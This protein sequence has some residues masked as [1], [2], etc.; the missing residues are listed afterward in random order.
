MSIS[1]CELRNRKSTS[2]IRQARLA[3]LRN[4]AIR[5]R[6]FLPRGLSMK[7]QISLAALALAFGLSAANAQNTGY[8]ALIEQHIAA[9]TKAAK[10]DMPGP[11]GLC[12]TATPQ[13]AG[14]FMDYYRKMVK[15][16]PLQPMQ[17]MDELYFLGN[18]WTSSWA[19]KTS[20]GLVIIDSLDNADEAKHYIEDGRRKLNLNPA[21]IKY[22]IVSHAHGDHYGGANYLKQKFNAH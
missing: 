9:A 15:E 10:S 5:A 21:D 14:S 2:I 12:K 16:P 20:G 4:P 3:G 18:Y 22:V 8:N 7:K 19:V 13:P 6:Q 1:E 17:V 11:L